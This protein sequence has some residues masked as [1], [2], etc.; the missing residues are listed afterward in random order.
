MVKIVDKW[1]AAEGEKDGLPTII[2]G[3]GELKHLIGLDSH[4]TVLRITWS[5]EPDDHSGLPDPDI[6][7]R[8]LA[9]EEAFMDPLEAEPLCIFYCVF[10]HNGIKEWSAYCSDIDRVG[11]VFNAALE[12]HE[13]YPIELA[14]EEDPEWEDYRAMLEGTGQL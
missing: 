11:E 5:Y 14:I 1:F 7:D 10:L 6:Q 3:R 13:V 12:G 9:F 4:P 8:M 2:R